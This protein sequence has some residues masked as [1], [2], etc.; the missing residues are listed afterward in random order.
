MTD[1]PARLAEAALAELALERVAVREGSGKLGVD[2]GHGE[3]LGVVA[4]RGEGSA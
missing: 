2:V 3:N 1:P 4:K